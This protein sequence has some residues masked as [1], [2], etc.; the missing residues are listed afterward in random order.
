M[1][2]IYLDTSGAQAVTSRPMGSVPS[3]SADGLMVQPTME[4]S[5][6]PLTRVVPT[7]MAR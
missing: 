1:G 3:A 2:I 5:T 4:Y 6:R 7:Q